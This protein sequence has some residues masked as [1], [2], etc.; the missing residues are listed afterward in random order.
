MLD[1]LG[2][3]ADLLSAR[4]YQSL[5]PCRDCRCARVVAVKALPVV[6]EVLG[7][8]EGPENETE[9]G[10]N[11]VRVRRP[12]IRWVVAVHAGAVEILANAR[13]AAESVA[14]LDRV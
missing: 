2:A 4:L 9:L 12:G 8:V 3:Q 14:P 11:E 6:Q 1:R 5:R 10:R 7:L 13:G